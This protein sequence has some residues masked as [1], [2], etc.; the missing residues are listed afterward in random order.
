[1]AVTILNDAPAACANCGAADYALDHAPLQTR[2]DILR[3]CHVRWY[4]V[5]EY[6][7]LEKHGLCL[8]EF[9]LDWSLFQDPGNLAYLP[10]SK[11]R[12]M[13]WPG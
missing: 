1:M 2:M 7:R 11:E 13:N 10:S 5:W 3:G 8:L 12:L 4:V 9:Y 6:V